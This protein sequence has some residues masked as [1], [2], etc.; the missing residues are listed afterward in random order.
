MA[1][2]TKKRA[3][4]I[5]IEVWTYQRDHPEIE[6]KQNLPEK[7]YKKIEGMEGECPWCEIYRD[8]CYFNTNEAIVLRRI[9]CGNCPLA[10]AGQKCLKRANGINSKSFFGKWTNAATL[11][12]RAKYAGLILDVAK[13]WKV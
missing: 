10:L 8:T 6:Y 2:L 9:N 11:K 3:K 5:L 13:G 7:I 4:A 12:T 1:K